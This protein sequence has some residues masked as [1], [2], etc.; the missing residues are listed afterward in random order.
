MICNPPK[1]GML[2]T[3]VYLFYRLKFNVCVF[4]FVNYFA[5][6]GWLN[7]Y[8]VGYDISLQGESGRTAETPREYLH[9]KIM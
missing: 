9:L 8:L 3:Q 1:S 7:V 4:C 6:F 5:K 2:Y